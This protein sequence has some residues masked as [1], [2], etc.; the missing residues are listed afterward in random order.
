MKKQKTD[1][2]REKRGDQ[3]KIVVLILHLYLKKSI[4]HNI[5]NYTY[6][7]HYFERIRKNKGRD[8]IV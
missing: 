5:K 6:I 3:Q 7:Q 2:E 4:T 1:R 8:L